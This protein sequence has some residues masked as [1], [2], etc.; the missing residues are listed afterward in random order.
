MNSPCLELSAAAHTPAERSA[1]YFRDEQELLRLALANDFS[2]RRIARELG[3]SSRQ[4]QRIF[5]ARLQTSPALWLREQR[6]LRAQQLLSTSGSVK[7]VAY[8]LG[9]TH[10]SQFCR[11][12]KAR[13]GRRPS[14]DLQRASLP[15]PPAP[16]S[17]RSA[18]GS[19]L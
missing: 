6:L 8:S 16:D 10:V 3:I 14:A 12:F 18:P 13:F 2:A 7:T 11:D 5:K 9:F 4:L 19:A 17:S 15:G 1:K